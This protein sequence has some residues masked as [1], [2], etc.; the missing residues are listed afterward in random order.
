M[1]NT[2]KNVPQSAKISPYKPYAAYF[3]C[4]WSFTFAAKSFYW[5]AGGTAGTAT[6]G[7]TITEL[8]Q[9]AW[10]SLVLWGTGISKALVGLLALALVQPWGSKVPRWM[11]LVAAWGTGIL[12]T[13]YA[14]ANLVVRGLMKAG[15]MSTPES[16]HSEAARWHLLLWDPWWLLGGFLFIRAAWTFTQSAK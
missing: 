11:L 2:D 3:A 13:L 14:G 5:A 15:I 7:D 12:F 16:M 1:E 6:I 10:F 9:S 4:V 8:S